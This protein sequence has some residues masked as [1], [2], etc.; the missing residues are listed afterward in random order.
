MKSF[1]AAFALAGYALAQSIQIAFPFEGMDVEAGSTVTIQIVQHGGSSSLQNM[2]VAVTLQHCESDSCEDV[3]SSDGL[4]PV[5]FVGPYNP[6]NLNPPSRFGGVY[7][8][9]SVVVDPSLEEGLAVFSVPHA[10]L[11]GADASFFTEIANVTIN[12]V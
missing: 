8:N 9:V 6:E 7:Q 2:G 1:L 4:G 12:I 10:A 5:L 11:V 3:A